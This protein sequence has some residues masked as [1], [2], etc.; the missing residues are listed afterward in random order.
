MFYPAKN[1]TQSHV[2]TEELLHQLGFISQNGLF[3]NFYRPTSVQYAFE[4][5]NMNDL[6]VEHT[7]TSLDSTDHE[8]LMS[9]DVSAADFSS[10]VSR[11]AHC[12]RAS[13]S[14]KLI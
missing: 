11:H 10:A 7:H 13:R 8:V 1:N 14:L 5:A 3:K 6:C 12:Y 4:H 2:H 9:A